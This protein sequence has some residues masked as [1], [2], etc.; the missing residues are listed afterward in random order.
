MVQESVI[1]DSMQLRS[2]TALSESCFHGAV[3]FFDPIPSTHFAVQLKTIVVSA[4]I[5]TRL[6]WQAQMGKTVDWKPPL[7]RLVNVTKLTQNS[8]ASGSGSGDVTEPPSHSSGNRCALETPQFFYFHKQ[9]YSSLMSLT[10]R[11][12]Y[13]TLLF[14]TVISLQQK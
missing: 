8:T 6:V 2:S 12:C 14:T 10:Q 11:G 9:L 3:E 7:C 5:R 13:H 4:C 1:I